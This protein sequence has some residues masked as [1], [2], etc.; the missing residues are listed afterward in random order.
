MLSM[1]FPDGTFDLVV[2][3]MAIHNVDEHALHDHRGRLQALDEAVRVLKPGGRLVIADFWSSVYAEHL[4]QQGMSDVEHR[5]LGCCFW[6]LPGVGA[7][8][9]MATKPV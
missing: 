8:L 6:Y 5:P 7:G 4:R 1:P 9:V 2:S 3:S